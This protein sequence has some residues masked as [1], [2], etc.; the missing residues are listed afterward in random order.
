VTEKATTTDDIQ[1]QYDIQFD[2]VN[3][4]GGVE[5][6]PMM[7]I[8]WRWDPKRLVFV[9]ARYKFVAKMLAG[10]GRVA[11]VG[12]GDGFGAVMVRQSVASVHGFDIDPRFVDWA[13][14]QAVRE[15]YDVSYSVA[16]A[17]D[18]IPGGPYDAAYS[19]DVIEHIPA[20]VEERYVRS[21]A[22]ALTRSGVCII[23]TPNITSE[24]YA[25]PGSK[26]G[27]I[28]LKSADTLRALLEN[29]FDNVFIF[30]MNDEM[31]HTGFSPMAHY[32][33]ALCAGVKPLSPD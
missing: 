28:N 15:K 30:S 7:G 32:V 2:D 24:A 10:K 17:L 26:I 5:L 29:F 25:S 16:N 14:R 12:C 18:G 20:D 11:E 6:G 19:L 21:I 1:P 8:A 23:G 22:S 13:K 4:R 9:L 3:R 27:H 33:M 31:L